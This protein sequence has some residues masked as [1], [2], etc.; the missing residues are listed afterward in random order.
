MNRLTWVGSGSLFQN[1]KVL[2]FEKEL[3]VFCVIEL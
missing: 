2:I 1:S 3:H